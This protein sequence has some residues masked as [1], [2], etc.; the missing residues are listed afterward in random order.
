MKNKFHNTY[1][2][3]N[4]NITLRIPCIARVISSLTIMIKTVSDMSKKIIRISKN[5]E[6]IVTS[7]EA[8]K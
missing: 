6:Y 7:N 1:E 4:Y 8:V 3:Y 5:C 2:K